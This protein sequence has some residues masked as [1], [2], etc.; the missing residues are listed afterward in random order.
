MS[1]YDEAR[2]LKEKL[3]RE[4]KDPLKIALFGQPGSGKSSIINKL[5]G[6]NAV[7][8]GVTTDKTK[9]AGI[10]HWNELLLV[11]LPGYGTTKF[12]DNNFFEKFEIDSFNLY[13]CVFSGKFHQADTNFFRELRSNGKVCLFVRNKHDEIWED[14]KEIDKLEK[15]I[16][17]DTC[18]Q[19]QSREKV[20]FTSCRTKK[21]IKELSEAIYRNIDE[22]QK[23]KW[24]KSAKAYSFEFLEMKKQACQKY[25]FVASGAA[26]TNALNPIPGVDIGI[27]ISVLVGLFASIRKNYGLT[28]EKLKSK[29]YTIPTL[30]PL[31][32]NVIKYATTEG[33]EI[34]IKRFAA[35]E[36]V[37]SISKYIPF[38]GQAIAASIGY[39]II[40]SAGMSY[41]EDCHELAKRILEEELTN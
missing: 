22:A 6:Y 8:T 40:R 15:E 3:K 39:A 27:D 38:V 34:L 19:T 35:R 17:E 11:D 36:I 21:G 28:D 10:V 31:I 18:R 20:Y 26:A 5:V 7:E 4:Q 37:K 16:L 25:V 29:E 30:T 32:N 9:V 13:L 12:P 41:L 24:V 33:I 1:I 14:N 2:T 23:A